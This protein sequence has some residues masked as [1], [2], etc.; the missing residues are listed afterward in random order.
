MNGTGAERWSQLMSET[1]EASSEQKTEDPRVRIRLNTFLA[2]FMTKYADE[3]A[4]ANRSYFDQINGPEKRKINFTKMMPQATKALREEG[5][6]AA[7]AERGV[8]ISR[9]LGKEAPVSKVIMM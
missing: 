7:L 1:L 2:Q 6:N 3:F 4:F 5:L 8:D 9:Y